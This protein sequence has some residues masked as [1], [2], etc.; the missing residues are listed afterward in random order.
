MDHRRGIH[1]A[2]PLVPGAR[3][4]LGMTLRTLPN[5]GKTNVWL[6]PKRII[7]ALTVDGPFDLDPCAAPNPRPWP[8]A[9]T[10]YA[11]ADGDGFERGWFGQVWMNPPFGPHMRNWL[12]RLAAH[13][14]GIALTYSRTETK[15]F[16][17][18][19]WDKADGVFFIRGR[20]RFCKPDGTPGFANGGASNMLI[21]Y[22]DATAR[23]ERAPASLGYFVRLRGK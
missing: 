22:G 17:E 15:A 23:L 18:S 19:V 1:R 5:Q 14:N 7:D 8:T 4:H 20:I 21:G 6:T 12:A 11:E 2:L 13:G 3:G 16:F 9:I 10:H